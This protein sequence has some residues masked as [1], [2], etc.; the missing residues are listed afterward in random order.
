MIHSATVTINHKQYKRTY[1][2]LHYIECDGITYIEAVDPADTKRK[3][4]ESVQ[5]LTQEEIEKR[6]VAQILADCINS[7]EL[8]D[9]ISLALKRFYPAWQELIDTQFT[10]EKEGY[11]FTYGDELYKTVKAS[12]QFLPNWIP[13][14]GTE[15]IFERIDEIHLGT[16]E[17][18]IPYKVNMT[19]YADKYYTEDGILY[20][21]I[22]NSDN[23]LQN[24]AYE[25]VGQ[26]F[27]VI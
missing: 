4:A 9:N 2:D 5:K 21:C 8:S 3:Y 27:E 6:Y 18:P 19:V 13:G 14:Q 26:Y 25:L 11:K 10:A 22:R 16:K 1:S 17:D 15:S 12:Q 23:P 20:R 24:K 7:V